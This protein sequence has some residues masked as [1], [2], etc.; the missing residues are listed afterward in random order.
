MSKKITVFKINIPYDF[1]RNEAL[2]NRA[3]IL[4]AYCWIKRN[5]TIDGKIHSDLSNILNDLG[6]TYYPDKKKE[7]PKQ[8][9]N[10]IRGIDYL[11]GKGYLILSDGDY[12]FFNNKFKMHLDSN[13]FNENKYVSLDYA[14]FDFI[15]NYE[16]RHNKSAMLF[17]LLWVKTN[18]IQEKNGENL[19]SYT[20]CSYKCERMA[21][22][23]GMKK[24]SVYKY[25]KN[26]SCELGI[27]SNKPL[28]NCKRYAIR[29]NNSPIAFPCI[30]VENNEKAGKI[31]E[32]KKN[33]IRKKFGD[34]YKIPEFDIED[35]E[36][37]RELDELF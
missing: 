14:D 31:I 10:V 27:D 5:G 17:T 16:G 33:Q 15:M 8:L 35:I 3:G 1:I 13:Y 34:Y 29:V 2:E 6:L 22:Y 12:H 9:L 32:I 7:Y 30:Y 11:C 37:D 36:L 4:M 26:L 18:F 25:L 21:Q 19:I 20:A 24:A 23:M 28:C